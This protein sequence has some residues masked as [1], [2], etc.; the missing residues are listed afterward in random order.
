V[1]GDR[2]SDE[3]F[4]PLHRRALIQNRLRRAVQNWTMAEAST[5]DTAQTEETELSRVQLKKRAK[6]EEQAKKK[7]ERA[8]AE[9]EKRLAKQAAANIVRPSA[10][11]RTCIY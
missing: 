3:E 8:A 5:N 9:T 2:P 7:A 1:T 6:K 11:P 10:V 4:A